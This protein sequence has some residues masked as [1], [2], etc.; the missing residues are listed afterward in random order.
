VVAR[1]IEFERSHDLAYLRDMLEPA[2]AAS[3]D[4]TDLAA[5][6]PWT[7]EGRYR[8]IWR[9]ALHRTWTSWWRPPAGS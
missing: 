4:V 9:T 2:D 1:G 8:P 6:N 7:I 3:F 5:L